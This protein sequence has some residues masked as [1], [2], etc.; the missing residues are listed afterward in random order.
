MM[1]QIKLKNSIVEINMNIGEKLA[2]IILYLILLY[3]LYLIW[4]ILALGGG[5]NNMKSETHI[6]PSGYTGKVYIFFNQ[7]EGYDIEYKKKDR[8]YRIPKS[9]ILLTKFKPNKGW[10][11][12]KDH[13][14]FYYKKG[15]SLTLLKKFISG[16]D[17]L[18]KI[19][20]NSIVVF[21]YGIGKGWEGFNKGKINATTYIVDSL[22]N[23][24][25]RDYNLTK[26]EFDK[27]DN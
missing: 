3:G 16:R 13:L 17:S 9:G 5:C 14:K 15:D 20:S 8:I 2:K 4:A 1:G 18:A 24:N 11:D 10:I 19:D 6:L 26:E 27:W 22:K 23:F 12:T 21:E 7:E 25:K